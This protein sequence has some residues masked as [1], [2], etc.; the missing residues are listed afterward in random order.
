LRHRLVQLVTVGQRVIDDLLD[1][2]LVLPPAHAEGDHRVGH[3]AAVAVVPAV[4][5]IPLA[6]DA[7][8]GE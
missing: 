6:E 5:V 4:L 8:L 3:G 1:Q 7:T 2:L